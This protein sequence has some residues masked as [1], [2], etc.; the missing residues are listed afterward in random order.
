MKDSAQRI[1]SQL[2]YIFCQKLTAL[3]RGRIRK[4]IP[5]HPKQVPHT[6]SGTGIQTRVA[7]RRGKVLRNASLNDFVFVRKCTY[8]NLD[9]IAYYTPKLY[10]M[11]YCS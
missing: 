4:W 3:T 9:S 11:T 7:K 10:G 2:V 1:L 8:T 6:H 5:V